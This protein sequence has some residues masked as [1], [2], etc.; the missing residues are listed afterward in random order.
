MEHRRPSAR[1]AFTR[2]RTMLIAPTQGFFFLFFL[3]LSPFFSLSFSIV[4]S[5]KM[6]KIDI[7]RS[8][9]RPARGRGGTFGDPPHDALLKIWKRAK[10]YFSQREDEKNSLSNKNQQ[11]SGAENKGGRPERYMKSRSSET[12]CARARTLIGARLVTLR[13]RAA[14]NCSTKLNTSSLRCK[15]SPNGSLKPIPPKNNLA[16]NPALDPLPKA[17][18]PGP[19]LP[20]PQTPRS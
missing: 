4:N 16:H 2:T 9:P 8:R 7:G 10:P 18:Y 3:L 13:A 15:A 1:D 20:H 6:A 12:T 5:T 11:H 19:L 17:P 14:P